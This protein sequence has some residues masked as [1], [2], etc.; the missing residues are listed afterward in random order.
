MWRCGSCT[1]DRPCPACSGPAR[2]DWLWWWYSPPYL[3][4]QGQKDLGVLSSFTCL[5]LRARGL[6]ILWIPILLLDSL[7]PWGWKW[8][9]VSPVAWALCH[10]SW[11]LRSSG[12]SDPIGK[13]FLISGCFR[14]RT[15]MAV[16]P[17]V[18]SVRPSDLILS[19]LRSPL[20][21][22]LTQDKSKSH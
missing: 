18:W 11:R 3:Q 12:T 19:T 21:A 8:M 17:L 10:S 14:I 13:M 1:G 9:K 20:Q 6:W 4:H 22:S 2:C 15:R 7:S 5:C 16:P